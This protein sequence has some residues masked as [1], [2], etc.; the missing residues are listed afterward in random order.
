MNRQELTEI[1]NF[2]FDKSLTGK[3][4]NAEKISTSIFILG[5]A[6]LEAS[7]TI[8]DAIMESTLKEGERYL[9]NRDNKEPLTERKQQ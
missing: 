4:K 9:P 2:H 6:I 3:D 8:A 7:H 1:Y 5:V